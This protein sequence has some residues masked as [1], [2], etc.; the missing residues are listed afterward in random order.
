MSRALL[1]TIRCEHGQPVNLSYHQQR[2]DASLKQLDSAAQYDL[3][4]LI[5]PPDSALYRCRMVYNDRSL[6]I[7]YLPYQKRVIQTLQLIQA[8][9]LEYTLKYADRTELDRLFAQKGD[10]DDILV[11]QNGLI[12]DTSIANIAF[13]DGT[14]WLTPKHPLLKGTT[15]ARL[16][17]EK[18]L[19]EEDIHLK[20]LDRFSGFALMNAMID[21]DVVKNGIISP[22]KGVDNAV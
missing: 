14:K 17:K 22:I 13:F 15:R 3:T 16:L 20:D 4:S 7:E 2:V 8:D 10:A 11:M 6:N 21:F 19:F 5:S 9:T 18:R 1:E 12:T